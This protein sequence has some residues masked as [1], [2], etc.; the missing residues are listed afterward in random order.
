MT[1]TSEGT[2]TATSGMLDSLS[3]IDPIEG[4]SPV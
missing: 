4:F 1:P 2:I 3:P